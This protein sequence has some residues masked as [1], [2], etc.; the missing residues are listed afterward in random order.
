MELLCDMLVPLDESFTASIDKEAHAKID[1]T[2]VRSFVLSCLR[3]GIRLDLKPRKSAAGLVSHVSS[4]TC[5][6][7]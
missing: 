2:A 5:L 6:W 4:S 7:C 3:S 1:K